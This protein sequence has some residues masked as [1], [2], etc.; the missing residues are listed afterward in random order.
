AR[1][2]R[3]SYAREHAAVSFA[4]A[5][6]RAHYPDKILGEPA[7][8]C[9]G[10]AEEALRNAPVHVDHT[11]RTPRYN[12][13]AIELHAVTARWIGETGVEIYDAAQYLAG[14]RHSI[15]ASFGLDPDNV[16][17]I[18][19]FVGGGFGGKTVWN[20]HFLCVA[21]ARLTGR[22]VRLVL[23]REQEFRVVGGRTLSEQRVALGAT[24][25]GR[26]QALIHTGTT[27]VVSHN[28]FPEQFSFPARHLYATDSYLIAQ[29]V[30]E[31]DTVANTSMRAPGESIGTFALECA[32]DELAVACE[33]DPIELRRRLEPDKDPT[34]GTPFSARH[35]V[36][37]YRRGAERFDWAHRNRRPGAQRD[38]EWLIGQGVA[39]A[40]YPYYRMAGGSARVQ[41]S[42][43]G[44][45]L[46]Q[47]AAHEMG[48]GTATVQAQHA[49][50]R[51]GLPLTAV[52]FQYGD[53]RLPDSPVAGGSS[54]TVSI[55]AAVSAA[56]DKLIEQLLQLAGPDSPLHG[57]QRQDLQIR[58]GGIY[59]AA[60][61]QGASFVALLQGAGLREVVAEA[62]AP[63]PEEMQHY[64]MHSFGAQFCEVRV[65]EVT[66]EVRVSRWL[67][68]FD[69]GRILNPRTAASQFRGGIVM[70]IGMALTEEA[71]FDERSG[72]HVNASLSEYHVPVHLDI[73]AIEV[74]WNDLPDPQAPLGARGIG[75][76]GITGA[77][78]AIA[79]A[80][81]NATGKRI[82]DLPITLDKVL[83]T[84]RS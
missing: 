16:R 33:L 47:A 46:V 17:V 20:H 52:T 42:V 56:A 39:T 63:K 75:E 11:Y 3:V 78:A 66:G 29:Q 54:Q 2:V 59:R 79:N 51:L 65:S 84:L 71:F 82:R 18:S 31:L 38:G 68:S 76:I 72:R 44:Q 50:D 73:P 40:L 55:A 9:R 21:A 10:D 57:P 35:I 74:I 60:D 64:S 23:N 27:A 81:Y 62:A 80:I 15:A 69:T 28:H 24:R 58:D 32:I 53:S 4:Q 77:A 43:E 1:D 48:M 13:N 45:V 19:R 70:G 6:P 61:G 36:E 26:L 30:V 12:H 22:P 34:K 49:A 5:R 41:L 67:G 7:K 8:I 83:A 25:D 14:T 37:A